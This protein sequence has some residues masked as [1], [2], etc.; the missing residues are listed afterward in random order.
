MTQKEKENF[1]EAA[2]FCIKGCQYSIDDIHEDNIA[3]GNC[4]LLVYTGN[5]ICLLGEYIPNNGFFRHE[6]VKGKFTDSLSKI[7]DVIG[8][9]LIK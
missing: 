1:I 3:P 9:M 4:V 5:G 8:W 7:N 2:N 6:I